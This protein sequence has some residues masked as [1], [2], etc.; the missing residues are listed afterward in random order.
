MSAEISQLQSALANLFRIGT[1]ATVDHANARVTVAYGEGNVSGPV[2]W[3]ASRAGATREWNP[4]AVGEQ[5]CLVSPGGVIN[6]GFVLPGGIYRDATPANGSDGGNVELDLPEGATWR[7]TVGDSVVTFANGTVKINVGGIAVEVTDK[8]TITGD[9]D[10]T[11]NVTITGEVTSTGDMT[12]G[13]I[14]LQ[15]HLHGGV[16]SGSSSTTAPIP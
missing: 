4:P 16:E 12:A 9:V 14:S 5:V 8:V 7:V 13:T 15:T 11:G 6:A 1:I 3:M 10:I 2:P